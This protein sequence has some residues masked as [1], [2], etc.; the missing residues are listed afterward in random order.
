MA[1]IIKVDRVQSDSNLAFNVAG[2][3]VAFMDASAL[4]LVGSSIVANGSTIVSGSKVVT[5]AQPAGSILQVVSTTKTDTFVG[6]ANQTW[7]DITGLSLAITPISATSK[8]LVLFEVNASCTN[9]ASLRLLRNSTPIVGTASSNRIP[10]STSDLYVS[11][12]ASGKTGSMSYLDSPA[13]TSEV[14]YKIQYW[15]YSGG[16]YPV[17]VNMVRDDSDNNYSF[18]SISSITIMEVAV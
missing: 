12:N 3:N 7:T 2:A 4:R 9:N 1:G 8:L 15:A 14:T 16:S 6:S 18:R 13:T 17:Y 10:T 5:A 11:A